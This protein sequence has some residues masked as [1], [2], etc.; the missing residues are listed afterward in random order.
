[1]SGIQQSATQPERSTIEASDRTSQGGLKMTITEIPGPNLTRVKQRQRQM[2]ASGNFHAVAT[3]I[4]PVADRLCDAADLQAGSRVLDVACGSGNAAIAAARCGCDVVGIDYVPALLA[5]GRLRVMA[6]GLKAELLEGD[7]EAIQFPDGSFDA[8]LSVYGSMFAPNH[9]QAAAE[10]T[11]VCR[12]GGTIGLATW[13]PEGF[14][15]EL[16]EVLAA[17]VPPP[18]GVASPLLWGTEPYLSDLFGSEIE[19]LACRELTFPLRFRSAEAYVDYFRTFHGPTVKAF[20]AVGAAGADALFSDLV[21]LVQRHAG[22]NAGP[23]AIPA[24]WLETVAIRS[25]KRAPHRALALQHVFEHEHRRLRRALEL[26]DQQ[27]LDLVRDGA[28]GKRLLERRRHGPDEVS[29]R[30]K[31]P[32][33]RQVVT[34]SEQYP[35]PGLEIPHEPG[36]EGGLADPWL[37]GDQDDTTLPPRCRVARLRKRSQRPIALEQLHRSTR[38][39]GRHTTV[40]ETSLRRL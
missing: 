2:W 25:T 23:V 34:G 15:G 30:I 19:T 21:D 32:W 24:K 9:E 16:L 10:L 26:R 11:R 29:N 6:E 4:Q 17:H 7:A 27:T 5:R 8:V 1:M 37:P 33:N 13:R 3:L 20:A 36:D 40:S 12:P 31:R 35:R 39:L 18:P 28:A 38:D 22:T 14:I